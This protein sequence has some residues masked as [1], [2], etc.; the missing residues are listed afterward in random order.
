MILSDAHCH[1]NKYE[2]FPS[3]E[4]M[5][6]FICATKR[7]DFDF[8][9]CAKSKNIRVALGFHPYFL[10]R[11]NTD[12][13]DKNIFLEADAIGEIGLDKICDTDFE[14]QRFFFVKQLELCEDLNKPCVLHVR[15]SYDDVIDILSYMNFSKKILLHAFNGSPETARRFFKFD[16]WFSFGMREMK[17]RKSIESLK[18][19]PQEKIMIETDSNPNFLNLKN[20]LKK[21]SE[22]QNKNSETMSNILNENFFNFFK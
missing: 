5:N 7:D 3:Y 10:K 1:L 16:T 19:V 2:K 20:A 17:N 11:E 13:L 22:I 6:L 12:D 4:N 21:I 18:F 14:M 9:L 8:L 15:K